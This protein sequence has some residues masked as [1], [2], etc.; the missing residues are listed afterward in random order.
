MGSSPEAFRCLCDVIRVAHPAYCSGGNILKQ[1]RGLIHLYLRLS[2]FA[3]RSCSYLTAQLICHQLGTVADS[4]N[5]NTHIE[6]RLINVRRFL[7]VYA[8]WSSS[9]DNALGVHLFNG[10]Q[11]HGVGV[12]FAVDIAFADTAGNQLVILAAEVQD[13]NHLSVHGK[14]LFL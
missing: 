6:N 9:K 12:H 14:L 4:Q 13:N 7:Q 3:D 11:R 5:R 2:V 1:N 10:F 8:V